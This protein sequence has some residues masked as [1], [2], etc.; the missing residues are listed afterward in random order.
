MNAS[1]RAFH[2][3]AI[4]YKKYRTTLDRNLIFVAFT[5]EAGDDQDGLDPTVDLC[6]R[7]AIPVYVV[8]VPAPFGRK[9]TLVKWVDPDPSFDQTPQWGRVDQGPE[10]SVAGT[11]SDC[12]QWISRR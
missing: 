3:A 10:T 6:R 4:R 2:A 12:L 11:N 5:D 1:L 9:E 7:L 8:G